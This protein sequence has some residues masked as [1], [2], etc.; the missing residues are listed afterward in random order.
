MTRLIINADDFGL[1]SGVNQSILDL[2]NAGA[3]SSATLMTAADHTSAAAAGTTRHL[4]LSVG[5]HVVLVDGKP[6][7]PSRDL[8]ELTLPSGIFRPTLGAFVVD[9]TRG[10]IPELEIEI[11]AIAQIRRLQA[12]GIRVTH[13]DTHKHTHIYPGVLRPLIRAA[14]ARGVRAIRNPFEPDWALKATHQA[15]MLRRVQV[16]LLRTLR[17]TFLRLVEQAGLTTTDGSIGLLATGT[18]DTS[19]I[20][21]LLSAMPAGT[22]E[23]ICHPGYFDTELGRVRTRLKASRMVEHAALQEVVPHFLRDHPEVSLINYRQLLEQNS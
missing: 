14:L 20:R 12:L 9:L 18:L 16:R 19:T 1:T 7:L 13:L 21:S 22:W 23:L 11:E 8:S 17:R 3:L 10:G 6:V 2:Y 4:D 5:C 15:P